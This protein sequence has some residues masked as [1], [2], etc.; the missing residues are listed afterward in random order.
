MG[1]N[2]VG[3]LIDRTVEHGVAGQAKNEVDPVHV[4]PLHDLG[5]AV[6]AV[7]PDCDL[8]LRPVPADAAD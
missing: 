8:S 6:M 5:A 1:A 2:V 7:A 4:A 3:D